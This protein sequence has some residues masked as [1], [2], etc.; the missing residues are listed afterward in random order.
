MKRLDLQ[1]PRLR[2]LVPALWNFYRQHENAYRGLQRNHPQINLFGVTIE[3]TDNEHLLVW[4]TTPWT[5]P[6]IS[7]SQWTKNKSTLWSKETQVPNSG[8]SRL[9]SSPFS[10]MVTDQSSKPSSARV[11][12][13]QYR[14]PFDFLEPAK[15]LKKLSDKFHLVVPTDNM[16]L[17]ISATDGTGLV[18][19]AVSAEPKTFSSAKNLDFLWSP[20]LRYCRL[21]TWTRLSFWSKC[22]KHPEIILD[23][24]GEDWTFRVEN[25]THRYPACW[26]CKTELVW[27]VADEWYISMD[28]KIRLTKITALCEKNDRRYQ[29]N[30]ETRVRS[31]PG[32]RLAYQH[33]TGSSARKIAIGVSLC[34]FGFCDT[35]GKFEV[36]GGFDELKSE[37][38]L[39]GKRFAGHTPHKPFIDEVKISCSCG[40][41]MSRIPD[42][43]NPG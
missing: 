11:S 8:F 12:W 1:R 28:K 4:T 3:G 18:H 30:L 41:E 27:K 5:I 29:E 26:R 37:L 10:K 25:I 14:S 15:D 7:P 31:W 36:L 35:C 24:L 17:P 32:V 22:Q 9:W 16:I 23:Y 2:P 40:G 34:Q 43:G 38:S 39:D 33:A 6:L 21:F 20:S 13:S 19:T 42:V